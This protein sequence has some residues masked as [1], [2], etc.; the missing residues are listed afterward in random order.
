M[1]MQDIGKEAFNIAHD[2]GWHK[3]RIDEFG[4]E[5]RTGTY[6]RLAL[7][8]SEVSEALE[9]FRHSG[10]RTW[11]EVD[12]KIQGF[13]SELADVIIRTLELAEW[14]SIEIDSIVS[15][16][17]EYNRRRNDVPNKD[18]TKAI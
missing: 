7:I 9:A 5:R 10:D 4:M 8:H 13:A 16:K 6:E 2:A 1:T 12:G 3:P 18:F 14:H 11:V 17:M 15:G